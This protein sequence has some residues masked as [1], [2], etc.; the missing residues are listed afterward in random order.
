MTE[1][2]PELSET[3]VRQLKIK[4]ADGNYRYFVMYVDRE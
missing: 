4:M 2:I 1:K 3:N